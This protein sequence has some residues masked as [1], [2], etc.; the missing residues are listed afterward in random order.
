MMAPTGW[1]IAVF[2]WLAVLP[3][4]HAL[5]Q[6]QIKSGTLNV[7]YVDPM[8][9]LSA[10]RQELSRRG[11]RFRDH[12]RL[13]NWL[14]LGARMLVTVTMAYGAFSSDMLA[15]S[16]IFMLIIAAAIDLSIDAYQDISTDL[17]LMRARWALWIRNTRPPGH[18]FK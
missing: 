13:R 17:G 10:V 5:H 12:I 14:E 2:L 7:E 18:Y 9:P 8:P 4:R 16:V 3:L 15:P 1:N 6:S 11:T